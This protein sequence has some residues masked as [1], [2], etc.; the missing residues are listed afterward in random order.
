MA[1]FEPLENSSYFVVRQ[2]APKWRQNILAKRTVMNK[3]YYIDK[4]C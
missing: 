4:F 2:D 3:P 1:I